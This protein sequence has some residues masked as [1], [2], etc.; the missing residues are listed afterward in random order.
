MAE[1]RVMWITGGSLTSSEAIFSDSST[2]EGDP[3]VLVLPI[4]QTEDG[5]EI[6]GMND[7]RRLRAASPR[8]EIL[9]RWFDAVYKAAERAIKGESDE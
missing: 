5:W 2:W 3:P 9:A 4:T 7:P 6:D 1:A 8:F